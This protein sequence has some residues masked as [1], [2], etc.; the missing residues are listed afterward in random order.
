MLQD[1]ASGR[2]QLTQLAAGRRPGEHRIACPRC[3][4]LK[5]R[6]RDDALALR[7]DPDGAA[8]AFCHR[9]GWR[10][11]ARPDRPE[12]AGNRRRERE[13]AAVR[14]GELAAPADRAPTGSGAALASTSPEPPRAPD[15][16]RLAA[17]LACWRRAR[18]LEPNTP[19]WRYLTE[20]RRLPIRRLVGERLALEPGRTVAFPALDPETSALRWS[21]EEWHPSGWRGPALV[22]LVTDAITAAPLTTH[23]TWLAPGGAG[24]API[25]RPRLLWRGLPKRNGCIRLVEDAEVT[26]E[27][28][29]AEGIE[30]ALAIFGPL[31][32]AWSLIDAGN[33]AALPVLDGVERLTVAVDHD[34]AGR[35]AALE[36]ARRWSAAGREVVELLPAEP[37]ADLADIVAE[38]FGNDA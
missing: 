32:P 23:R 29:V 38:D 16:D 36:L 5:P 11:A 37:G 33:L 28:A 30:T 20:A 10:A 34:P 12:K 17:A 24:K 22:A 2:E 6:P 1:S 35:R 14:R 25:D 31:L 19:A 18:P 21:P 26:S 3:A 27:L 4:A 9:C 8:V 15:R 7:V 13:R